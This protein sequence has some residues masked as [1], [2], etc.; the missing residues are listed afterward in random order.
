M[1]SLLARRLQRRA[2]G[3]G[4]ELDVELEAMFEP[5]RFGR[6]PTEQI[7]VVGVPARPRVYRRL[8]R[9]ESAFTEIPEL[10]LDIPR[11]SWLS[12]TGAQTDRY[13]LVLWA[14]T[15]SK[16]QT[17]PTSGATGTHGRWAFRQNC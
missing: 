12:V 15:E 6:L 3:R 1:L 11:R 4:R 13:A 10:H 5:V 9:V 16:Q 14:E 8:E 7:C 17:D 2:R